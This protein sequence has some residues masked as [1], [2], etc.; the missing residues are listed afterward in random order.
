MDIMI[1]IIIPAY[2]AS[3]YIERCIESIVSQGMPNLKFIEII[4]ANDGSIDETEVIVNHIIQ[5]NPDVNIKIIS[6]PNG[7]LANARNIGIR[8]AKGNYFINLDSDDFLE[9]GIIQK[10]LDVIKNDESIDCCFYG[11]QD[12]IEETGI[13][14]G[15]YYKHFKYLDTFIN[16]EQAF[17]AKISKKI[18]ICQG[19]ACYKKNIF[20]NYNLENIKGINQGEDFLFIMSFLA[21]SKKVVSIPQIGV[22]I[23]Y[24]T[25]SMM[26]SEFN[27]THLEVFK[28]I[29]ELNKRLRTFPINGD[30]KTMLTWVNIEYEL[31]RL[32]IAKKIILTNTNAKKKEIKKLC[33]N[34]IPD[35]KKI[36]RRKLSKG[37]LIESWLFNRH[38]Y[39]YY[40]VVNLYKKLRK[41]S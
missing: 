27:K 15:E 39:I 41:N 30:I 5:K 1:S 8:E 33:D 11:F 32:A 25:D 28:A 19:S 31:E 34:L 26:H 37:K 38:L 2:N 13:T 18:W 40:V 7:G 17:I 4:I 35:Y 10:L 21:C 3:K 24:R 20:R 16:G 14:D 6:I 12:Y 36:D 22:N 9:Q 29:N 23:S